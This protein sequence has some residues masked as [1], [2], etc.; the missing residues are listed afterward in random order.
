M[1][2]LVKV[3]GLVGMLVATVTAELKAAQLNNPGAP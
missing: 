2:S 1:T 3:A